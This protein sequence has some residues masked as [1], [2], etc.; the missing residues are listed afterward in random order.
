MFKAVSAKLNSSEM[1]ENI[2][3]FWKENEIFLKTT[4]RRL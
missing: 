3:K 1:E 2:L 4:R